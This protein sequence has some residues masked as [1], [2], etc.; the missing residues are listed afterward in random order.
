MRRMAVLVNRD[1]LKGDWADPA[2]IGALFAGRGFEVSIRILAGSEIAEAARR[3]AAEPVEIA[4]A[5]GGDGTVSAVAGALAGTG[6]SL[7]ILPLGTLNH[8]AGDLG[9]PEEMEGAAEVICRGTVR[10]V[11][12]GEVNGHTFINNSAIGLYPLAVRDRE[13]SPV[14]GKW[15]AMGMALAKLLWRF[16]RLRLRIAFEQGDVRRQTPLVFIGNN[17]YEMNLL[18]PTHRDRLDEGVLF[19]CL[20][21]GVSRRGLFLIALRAVMGTLDADRDLETMIATDFRIDA[22]RPLEIAND[23]EV[24]RLT[25]PLFYR[26]HPRALRVIAGRPA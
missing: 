6:I 18:T 7:G 15:A 19:T 14:P 12:L 8:F 22:R 4:V 1:A 17:V 21:P 24:K 9:V 23:G 25:P 2:R 5:A 20:T 16:P 3:A 10:E 13:A 26:I 11:D